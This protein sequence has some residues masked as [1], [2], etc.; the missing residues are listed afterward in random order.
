[1]CSQNVCA[2]ERKTGT[3]LHMSGPG[4]M[5]RTQRHVFDALLAMGGARP[6]MA[7]GLVDRLA[8]HLNA[9]CVQACSQWKGSRLFVSKSLVSNAL[10]C[11]GLVLANEEHP[12]TGMAGPTAVGIV[13]HRAVQIAYTHPRLAIEEC[14][15]AGLDASL[16]EEKFLAFWTSI[17][18][19]RQSD[20]LMQMTSKT[21]SFLDSFPPLAP[22][23]TPRFEEGFQ[24]PLG[25]VLLGARCDLVLGRPKPDMKQTMFLADLK[26]G[27]L[28][29]HHFD[30]AMFY[31][32]V[33]TLH[34]GVAPFRS[35]VYS[36]SSYEWS[37]PDV[38]EDRLFVAADQVIEAVRRVVAAKSGQ[39]ELSLS[40]GAHCTYCPAKASCTAFDPNAVLADRAVARPEVVPVSITAPVSR[41]AGTS[42]FDIED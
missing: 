38:T 4:V 24:T 19:G 11:E 16:E 6:V 41:S 36:L 27:S 9:G 7:N 15:E 1:M 20:L 14:V 34:Y 5:N 23:W 25:P 8:Q 22:S 2:S 33:A 3:V 29:D 42:V 28:Q 17:G 10:R 35:T 26:T 21:V 40:A 37:D 13:A 30:E 31:A 12:M 18:P 32:L 39:R